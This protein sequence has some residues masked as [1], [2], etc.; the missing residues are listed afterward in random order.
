MSIICSDFLNKS[1]GEFLKWYRSEWMASGITF[2]SFLYGIRNGK[3][4]LYWKAFKIST[5][6]LTW[7][8]IVFLVHDDEFFIEF[9]E[10]WKS[11]HH[12]MVNNEKYFHKHETKKCL[13]FH[14]RRG[15]WN[16]AAS[17][18]SENSKRCTVTCHSSATPY[19][20]CRNITGAHFFRDFN[21]L[22]LNFFFVLLSKL[23][24]CEK[25]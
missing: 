18:S 1:G 22:N 11:L 3:N 2:Y 4:H 14:S 19:R 7:K 17:S 8:K 13:K 25:C 24:T 20:E 12:C 9:N 16:A 15:G 6:F 10:T 23:K 21:N 5:K